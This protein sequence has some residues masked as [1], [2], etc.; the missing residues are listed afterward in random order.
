ML[1]GLQRLAF[2]VLGLL[3]GTEDSSHACFYGVHP[4]VFFVST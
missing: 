3:L 1:R 4:S 2:V